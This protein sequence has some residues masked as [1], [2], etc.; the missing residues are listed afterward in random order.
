MVRPILKNGYDLSLSLFHSGLY[1]VTF[2]VHARIRSKNQGGGTNIAIYP[3][4]FLFVLC[5]TYC[6]IDIAQ[7]LYSVSIEILIFLAQS[8]SLIIK[9]LFQFHFDSGSDPQIGLA[10][11]NMNIANT[12]LYCAITF[13]AQ[14]IL[15]LSS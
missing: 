11:Y 7:T 9:T 13:L 15:V 10:S 6:I 12:A 3:L 4:S 14:G 1:C 8:V 2:A 5:T